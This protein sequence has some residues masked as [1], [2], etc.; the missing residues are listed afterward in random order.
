MLQVGEKVSGC[1]RKLCSSAQV[2]SLLCLWLLAVGCRMLQCV[3]PIE[4]GVVASAG[5]C[6]NQN[7]PHWIFLSVSLTLSLVDLFFI[8]RFCC[9][10]S[11]F[12]SPSLLPNLCTS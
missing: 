9:L 2:F 10:C 12:L 11:S 4:E 8:R 5:P 3:G 6:G 1:Q 7:S